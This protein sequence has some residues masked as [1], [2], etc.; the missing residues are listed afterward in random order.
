MWNKLYAFLVRQ[1]KLW[2]KHAY[3]FYKEDIIV[4]FC[5][6]GSKIQMVNY[7][8]E[9]GQE[10]VRWTH[11]H[12]AAPCQVAVILIAI[13]AIWCLRIDFATF[14]LQKMYQAHFALGQVVLLLFRSDM[15]LEK[16]IQVSISHL[17]SLVA[18][19]GESMYIPRP[20]VFI[21]ELLQTKYS[22]RKVKPFWFADESSPTKPY[23]FN[24]QITKWV[25]PS[26][27]EVIVINGIVE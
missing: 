4:S 15:I 25:G 6:L 2:E 16:M 26:V 18:R 7:Q 23:T 17:S 8:F 21:L 20:Q 12:A 14:S 27:V 22:E 9:E 19:N 10:N 5:L 24:L 13:L 3:K 1:F 11:C